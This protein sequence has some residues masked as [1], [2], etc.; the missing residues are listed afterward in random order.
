[1]DAAFWGS[2]RWGHFRW[3]VYRPDWDNIL[4]PSLKGSDVSFNVTR[5]QL[6]L[7]DADATTGWYVKEWTES[8]I[9]MVIQPRGGVNIGLPPGIFARLD[10]VGL[11]AAPVLVAEEIE[12]AGVFYEVKTVK[13]YSI[14]DSF[15][16]RECQLTELPFHEA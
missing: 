16:Y 9:E 15:M 13:P 3:G 8:T 5:R 6:S 1:M 14:G 10:A 2:M 4:L 7:G 11:T 12:D